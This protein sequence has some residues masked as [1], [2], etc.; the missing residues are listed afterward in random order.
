MKKPRTLK[1][2]LGQAGLLDSPCQHEPM[3]DA[4]GTPAA[5]VVQ[6]GAQTSV[7]S[8]FLCSHICRFCRC[9]YVTN[10]VLDYFGVPTNQEQDG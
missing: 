4:G 10:D 1:E 6:I 7:V 9:V 3:L 2:A 8:G 5:V